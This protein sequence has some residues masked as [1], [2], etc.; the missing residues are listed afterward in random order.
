M[1]TYNF[2]EKTIQKVGALEQQLEQSS[3]KDILG[4]ISYPPLV[5]SMTSELT[6]SQLNDLTLLITNYID[7][8]FYLTL[9]HTTSLAMHSHFTND[10]DTMMGTQTVLQTLIYTASIDTNIVLDSCK[11]IVEFHC[12]NLQSYLNKT[13]G[14]INVEIY[15]I[16]RDTSIASQTLQLNDIAVQWNI[17]ANTGSTT[18]N[19]MYRSVQFTG[20]K[21][22]NPDYD[23]IFQLRGSASDT[24]FT[25]R[26]NGLQYLYYSVITN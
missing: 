8:A 17:L 5:V 16:T 25:Y 23:C 13:T 22:K 11:S 24:S 12:P 7:P 2:P 18:G 19:T 3:F 20:L 9:D 10:Q 14:N 21:N 26:L 1:Y 6:V 15:D 4:G